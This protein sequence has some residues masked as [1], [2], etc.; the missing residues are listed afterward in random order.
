MSVSSIYFITLL[1]WM[2][3]NPCGFIYRNDK[4]TA[5]TNSQFQQWL[6]PQALWENPSVWTRAQPLTW[7]HSIPYLSRTCRRC[8]GLLSSAP[9]GTSPALPRPVIASPFALS[10]SHSARQC[11]EFPNSD[12]WCAIREFIIY[13]VNV[14][15]NDLHWI[16][17]PD[18]RMAHPDI[19]CPRGLV[20]FIL[21]S[22]KCYLYLVCV[23]IFFFNSS[24]LCK[25]SVWMS[26]VLA[27]FLSET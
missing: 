20:F 26:M 3:I 17:R 21:V 4:T 11:R 12:T 27:S 2:L 8:W 19:C 13:A 7:R 22:Q 10:V 16:Y 15:L 1:I 23:R 18:G 14:F 5:L 25:H 24:S 6:H 9:A